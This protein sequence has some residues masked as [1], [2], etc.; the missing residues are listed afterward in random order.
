MK[1]VIVKDL[2]SELSSSTLGSYI[3]KASYDAADSG[4]GLGKAKSTHFMDRFSHLTNKRIKGVGIATN[5]LLKR[6]PATK[7]KG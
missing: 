3:K 5:K 7:P 4:Y 6:I 1:L 2:F